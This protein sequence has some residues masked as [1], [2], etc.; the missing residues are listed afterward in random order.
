[1]LLTP[2]LLPAWMDALS[3]LHVLL[4]CVTC[5]LAVAEQ[6]ERDRRDPNGSHEATTAWF[7][8]TTPST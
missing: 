6:R 1:M 4:V 7:T 8:T 2:D 3:G 5:P